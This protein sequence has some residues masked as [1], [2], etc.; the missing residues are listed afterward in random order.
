MRYKLTNLLASIFESIKPLEKS[1]FS[2]IFSKSGTTIA[3]GRN[4]ALRL[5]G[6]S[7]IQLIS[8]NLNAYMC[9]MKR[10]T[11]AT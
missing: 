6:S 4:R 1:I 10:L 2:A 5:S 8:V 11:C 3:T 7:K 9:A